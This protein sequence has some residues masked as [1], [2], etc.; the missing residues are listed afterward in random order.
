MKHKHPKSKKHAL[1][2]DEV[3]ANTEAEE[4]VEDTE[5]FPEDVEDDESERPVTPEDV[6][7]ETPDGGASDED[8]KPTMEELLQKVKAAEK[9]LHM[10]NDELTGQLI[11]IQKQLNTRE[12]EFQKLA[13]AYR[14]LRAAFDKVEKQHNAEFDNYRRR[15]EDEKKKIGDKAVGDLMLA[16]LPSLDNLDRAMAML[17]SATDIDT[18]RDGISMIVNGIDSVLKD[19]GLERLESVGRLFDPEYHNAMAT[20]QTDDVPEGYVFDEMIPGYTMKGQ[21]I[22]PAMVRVAS[23]PDE[24]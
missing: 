1:D 7:I 24:K 6:I 8:L 10:Q 5:F 15:T 2:E 21:L 16:L 17:D 20:V 23:Q 3:F 19:N 11:K 12:E 13:S 18:V 4:E 9:T 22:R 14:K